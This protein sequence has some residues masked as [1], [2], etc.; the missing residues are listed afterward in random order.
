MIETFDLTKTFKAEDIETIALHNV[1]LKV[2]KGDFIAIMG[3]SGCGKT[4]FLNILGMIDSITN[5]RYLLFGQDVTRISE[6]QK[7]EIRKKT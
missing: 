2:E 6:K 1:S 4:T 5:G 3:P 7:T